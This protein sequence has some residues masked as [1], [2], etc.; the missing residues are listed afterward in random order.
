M[1][2]IEAHGSK[3]QKFID[4]A[5]EAAVMDAGGLVS[6]LSAAEALVPSIDLYWGAGSKKPRFFIRR[7][8]SSSDELV[9]GWADGRVSLR[10]GDLRELLGEDE[11]VSNLAKALGIDGWQ[12]SPEPSFRAALLENEGVLAAMLG[13]LHAVSRRGRARTQGLREPS[14]WMLLMFGDERQ[15]AGNLGYSDDARTVYKY[16]SHVPNSRQIREGDIVVVRSKDRALGVARI[17]RLHEEDGTKDRQRCPVCDTTA[18]KPRKTVSP[19]FRCDRGH[20]FDE[21]VAESAPARLYFAYFGES[22]VDAPE[23]LDS[24]DLRMACE[25]Y[26]GQLA[27]QKLVIDRLR[28]GDRDALR[29]LGKR[30]DRLIGDARTTSYANAD[31]ADEATPPLAPAAY[32]IGGVDTRESLMRQITTRRGQ[33]TFRQ[34]LRD[35]HGDRCMVTGCTLMDLVEAAHISPY[36]GST[37]HH[38]D[39]GL[40]L[41]VDLHT[42]FDLDLLGVHPEHLVVF[43]NPVLV[44][45]GYDHLAGQQLRCARPPSGEA[46]ESRWAAFVR[47]RDE[48]LR[49]TSV[50]QPVSVGA[51]STDG[52]GGNSELS[53]HTR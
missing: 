35:T 49:T 13:V 9:S 31:A 39:N 10:I 34:L 2:S 33:S 27:M 30:I 20:E 15:Y 28:N 12:G 8:G 47:R 53:E 23:G 3:R 29:E 6:L 16:D 5:T 25:N 43:I 40:L 50:A 14:V 37:D 44:E 45:A 17:E 36:R 38:P 18:L 32:K 41:R 51:P 26:N 19:R 7:A 48:A 1:N 52:T 4:A 24:A 11:A 22:F 46:L 21:P 42:L